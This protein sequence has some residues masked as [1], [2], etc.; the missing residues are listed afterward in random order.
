MA[1]ERT[2]Y[3]WQGQVA[4]FCPRPIHPPN[5]K[6]LQPARAAVPLKGVWLV[7][8]KSCTVVASLDLPA[9]QFKLTLRAPSMAGVNECAIHKQ[10]ILETDLLDGHCAVRLILP[11]ADS[12]TGNVTSSA[13]LLLAPYTDAPD[14]TR[15]HPHPVPAGL[16]QQA[17]VL[18]FR[19]SSLLDAQAFQAMLQRAQEEPATPH[20]SAQAGV[21]QQHTAEA[22]PHPALPE[23]DEQLQSLLVV[24]GRH[25]Q[26]QCQV[27]THEDAGTTHNALRHCRVCRL[28]PIQGYLADPEFNALVDRLERVYDRIEQDALRLADTADIH[29]A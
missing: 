1:A 4:V 29:M 27:F 25:T 26:S 21:A 14:D 28:C 7:A 22:L 17:Q 12:I 20:P 15:P 24:R 3:C 2:S 23:T 19:F 8:S 10:H 16:G 6:V 11:S 18:A 13:V 9:Q 5:S